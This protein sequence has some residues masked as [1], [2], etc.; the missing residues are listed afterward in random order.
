MSGKIVFEDPI[1]VGERVGADGS[2]I[3]GTC[4]KYSWLVLE[5]SPD[6]WSDAVVGGTD[7]TEVER[8]GIPDE[9]GTST[10]W[11]GSAE[12]LPL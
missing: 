11:V 5:D 6:W 1:V 12:V 8:G 2:C 10:G 4:G 9:R 3:S 7:G